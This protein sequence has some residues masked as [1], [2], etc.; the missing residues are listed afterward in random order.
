MLKT[1]T[2]QRKLDKKF[3]LLAIALEREIRRE[4][5]KTR[6]AMAQAVIDSGNSNGIQERDSLERTLEDHIKDFW[7]LYALA[8]ISYNVK[9]AE[10]KVEDA[11]GIVSRLNRAKLYDEARA[12]KQTLAN[13]PKTVERRVMT[14]KWAIDKKSVA[15]RIKNVEAANIKTVR[16]I[17]DLGVKNRKSVFDIAKDIEAY[18]KPDPAG[19][20]VAPWTLYRERFGRPK[21]YVPAGMPAGSVDYNAIRIARTESARTYRLATVEF[22][23]KKDYVKGYE[24]VISGSHPKQDECDDYAAQ[25]YTDPAEIPDGHPNCLCD[26]RPIIMSEDEMNE[27]R[28]SR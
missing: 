27:L 7:V 25:T 12:L 16:N 18:V 21:S 22:Y 28:R 11:Q 13:Y 23:S 14:R 1:K 26:V 8:L 2:R 5:D 15:T 17:I 4:L 3:I 24:W 9:I 10:L 20:R 6:D 19:R